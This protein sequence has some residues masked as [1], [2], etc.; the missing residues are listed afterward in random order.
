MLSIR[1][2]DNEWLYIFKFFYWLHVSCNSLANPSTCITLSFIGRLLMHMLARFIVISNKWSML[3]PFRISSFTWVVCL[4][5]CS[6]VYI[7]WWIY[8]WC[9]LR[10]S[11]L[12]CAPFLLFNW[13]T[14]EWTWYRFYCYALKHYWQ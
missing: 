7:V 12:N 13:K 5:S 6:T 3:P 2:N 11:Y 10:L 4:H 9:I 1:L 8:T 14:I